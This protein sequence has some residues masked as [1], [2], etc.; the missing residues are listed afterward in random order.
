MSVNHRH[1]LKLSK[2][3]DALYAEAMNSPV[4]KK[5]ARE[6][7]RA[8]FLV[9]ASMDHDDEDDA[10]DADDFDHDSEFEPEHSFDDE[11]EDDY[12]DFMDEYDDGFSEKEQKSLNEAIESMDDEAEMEIRSRSRDEMTRMQVA[13]MT[14]NKKLLERLSKD[15]N[16]V[17]RGIA[18]RRLKSEFWFKY[19]KK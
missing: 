1:V 18:K 12:S 7:L 9:T 5:Q 15:D 6:D 10:Y 11:L 17:V 14:N 4:M 8:G 13:E 3:I 16:G 19:L 2:V